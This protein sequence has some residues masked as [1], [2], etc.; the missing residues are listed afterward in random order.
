MFNSQK[1]SR[2]IELTPNSKTYPEQLST[3]ASLLASFQP[4]RYLEI[5][6]F[7]GRSLGLFAILSS[8]LHN[9]PLHI[10]SIDSWQGGDEHKASGF[11]MS[12]AEFRYDNVASICSEVLGK[13]IN[14]EKIKSLS[15]R[16]LSAIADREGFYDLILIDAGHKSKDVLEDLILSWPLLRKGGVVI[17]DDYTW[18]PKHSDQGNIL[19]ESPK[20]GI[21]SFINCYSDEVVILSML[22]LLQLYIMKDNPGQIPGHYG[23]IHPTSVPAP[24]DSLIQFL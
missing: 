4:S 20:M 8:S 6:A 10:T 3:L 16:A 17:L 19:L 12:G 5:G 21:D 14:L 13:C 9:S 24:L 7:E 18:Y 11:D 1:A 23:V 15:R 22:P 2:I